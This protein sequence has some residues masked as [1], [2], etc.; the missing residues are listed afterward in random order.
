MTWKDSVRRASAAELVEFFERVGA[1][2]HLGTSSVV[3]A[4]HDLEVSTEDIS[5]G[6]FRFLADEEFSVG[7][8]VSVLEYEPAGGEPILARVINDFGRGDCGRLRYGTRYC[9]LPAGQIDGITRFVFA[10]QRSEIRA[11]RAGD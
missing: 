3:S 9:G 4:P 8:Y 7:D 6:G 1:V 5:A 10:L 2:D 11:A